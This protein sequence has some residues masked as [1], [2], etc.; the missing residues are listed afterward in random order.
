MQAHSRGSL[1]AEIKKDELWLHIKMSSVEGDMYCSL[2][3][4]D[5]GKLPESQERFKDQ[6]RSGRMSRFPKT[7]F[8]ADR[9]PSVSLCPFTWQ[10]RIQ[11]QEP[12][13]FPH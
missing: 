9:A 8:I 6:K 2:L 13:T 5:R 3:R 7:V 4:L 12:Y 10:V 1:P 11:R